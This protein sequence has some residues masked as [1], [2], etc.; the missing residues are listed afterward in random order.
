MLYWN[1]AAY[2]VKFNA[3]P[4]LQ[5]RYLDDNLDL[6]VLGQHGELQAVE[7]IEHFSTFP[8][9]PRHRLPQF[10]RGLVVILA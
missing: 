1:E 4:S 7:R 9:G 2:G 5:Q 6:M 10:R 8:L 3:R